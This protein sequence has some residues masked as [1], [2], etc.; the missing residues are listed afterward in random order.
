MIKLRK[1]YKK[2]DLVVKIKVSMIIGTCTFLFKKVTTMRKRKP[3]TIISRTHYFTFILQTT[4][5]SCY[6]KL[7]LF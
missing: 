7:E 2:L 6:N 5:N 1:K 3:K 4:T